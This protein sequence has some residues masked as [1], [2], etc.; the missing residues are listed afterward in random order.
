MAEALFIPEMGLVPGS[1]KITMEQESYY[2]CFKLQRLKLNV[3]LQ[4]YLLTANYLLPGLSNFVSSSSL[5]CTRLLKYKV[6][7]LINPLS[8]AYC[9]WARGIAALFPLL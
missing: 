6:S 5:V 4:I 9:N 2:T 3:Q 8:M 1:G 7:E